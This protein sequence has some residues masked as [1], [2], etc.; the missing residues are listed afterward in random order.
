ML[1]DVS[2]VEIDITGS[3][4]LQCTYCYLKAGDKYTNRKKSLS[5][6]DIDNFIDIYEK[7]HRGCVKVSFFG[8]EP[9]IE[10]SKIRYTINRLISKI[11]H[12][13]DLSFR[14]ITN[15]TLIDDEIAKF[16][17]DNKV[18]IQVTLDGKKQTHD[19]Q[20]RYKKGV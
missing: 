19:L 13:N 7:K 1:E 10:F 14:I 17:H 15:G 4:N 6:N 12:K 20:R 9:L 18:H 2:D 16:C 5:K 11:D 8:G 3:C